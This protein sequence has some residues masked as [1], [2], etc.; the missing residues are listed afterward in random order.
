M[1]HDVVD[2]SEV[3]KGAALAAQTAAGARDLQGRAEREIQLMD[4]L[5]FIY[6]QNGL[7]DKAA[8]LM[9]ARDVLQSDDPNALLT[10]AVA[11]VRSAKP[12]RALTTLDRL[13]LLGAMNATFHLVRAQALQA[14][15]RHDEA[16]SAMRA[17]VAM[18]QQ[19]PSSATAPARPPLQS[20][21]DAETRAVIR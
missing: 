19:D 9:S 17:F 21:I 4:L 7:P 18:R 6:L 5:A 1:Q 10:L 2:N 15:E 3:G 20:D 12:Q 11:Q 16:A 13:A 14:V 8:V